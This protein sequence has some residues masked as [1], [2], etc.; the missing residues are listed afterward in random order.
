[1][2]ENF[3]NGVKAQHPAS[4]VTPS[5]ERTTSKEHL[6]SITTKQVVRSN[7]KLIHLKSTHFYVIH[8]S[9]L[10]T[11]ISYFNSKYTEILTLQMTA[12]ITPCSFTEVC[13]SKE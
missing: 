11:F 3:C 10:L 13:P 7:P 5:A 8:N 6:I 2:E 1:M 9:S 12:V 4:A